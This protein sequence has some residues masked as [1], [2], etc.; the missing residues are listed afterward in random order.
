VGQRD[1]WLAQAMTTQLTPTERELLRLA[2]GLMERLA[3]A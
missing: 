2:G 3:E 1:T